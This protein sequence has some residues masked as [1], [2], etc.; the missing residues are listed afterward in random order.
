MAASFGRDEVGAGCLGQGWQ[1]FAWA[2]IEWLRVSVK[3]AVAVTKRRQ[4]AESGSVIERIV[5]RCILS[6]AVA[7]VA[8]V[9]LLSVVG[10]SP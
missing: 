10:P 2:S 4:P 6:L 3:G 9:V 8:A 1:R 7:S 5:F